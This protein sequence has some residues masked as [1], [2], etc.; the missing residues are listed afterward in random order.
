MRENIF[1]PLGLQ[2][3]C[4]NDVSLAELP[5]G[6]NYGY[7]PSPAYAVA[8]PGW[9]FF[10]AYFGAGGIVATPNDMFSWLLF[11]MGI[12]QNKLLTPLLPALQSPSTQVKWNDWNQLGLGWFINPAGPN[13]SASIWKDGGIDGFNS[14]IAFL[15]STNPGII[16]SEAGAFVLVNADGML[17]DNGVEVPGALANDLLLIMQ[18]QAPPADKSVYPTSV[19]SRSQRRPI[20]RLIGVQSRSR[21]CQ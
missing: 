6:F 8:V 14:Y 9:P 11:N 4:F 13:W 20:D 18:G 12:T 3:K 17:D 15:P 1:V 16:P 5:L 10:P 21:D 2:A 19:Q 7:W